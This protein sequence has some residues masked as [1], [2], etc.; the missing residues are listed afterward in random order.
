VTDVIVKMEIEFPCLSTFQIERRQI[1]RA[2][3]GVAHL[4]DTPAKVEFR[5]RF[6]SD[7]LMMKNSPST[8][9]GP[10]GGYI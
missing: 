7:S 10:T 6:L 3:L 1:G 5:A 8:G 2:G 4:F 9:Q